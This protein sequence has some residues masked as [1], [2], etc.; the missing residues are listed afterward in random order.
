MRAS[1]SWTLPASSEVRIRSP[2]GRKSAAQ[3]LPARTSVERT[4]SATRGRH[5]LMVPSSAA[6]IT[7]EPS[8]E[9]AAWRT[10]APWPTRRESSAPL[11]LSRY[12][13]YVSAMINGDAAP[14]YSSGDAIR[15]IEEVAKNTLP[16][17]YAI[18]WSGMT[19]EEVLSGTQAI[20]IFAICL[21]F[22]Y[23]LLAAQS[24]APDNRHRRGR[25]GRNQRNLPFPR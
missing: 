14:G 1:Q 24:V 25:S 15:K 8:G 2:S 4:R 17:G 7:R 23:L 10:V 20:F 19:R 16:R 5:C 21:L 13:M 12:N 18:E 9:K 3:R 22:V 11:V 6:E